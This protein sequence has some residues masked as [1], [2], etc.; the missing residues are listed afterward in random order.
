MRP[1]WINVLGKTFLIVSCFFVILLRLLLWNS[2]RSKTKINYNLPQS[3]GII[4]KEDQSSIN[5]AR[6]HLKGLIRERKIPGISIAVSKEGKIVWSEAFGY[7]DLNKKIKAQTTTLF[8]VASVSKSFTAAGMMNLVENKKLNLHASVQTYVPEF[9]DKEYPVTPHLLASHQAGIRN[10]WDDSETINTIH[11]NSVISSLEKFKNDSLLFIPGTNFEYSNYGYVLLSALIER[12]SGKDFI[13]YM[14]ENVFQPLGM[15]NTMPDQVKDSNIAKSTF[16]DH[17]TPYSSNG[18]IVVSPYN[19]LSCKWAS[20][21]FLSTAEDMV[22]FANGHISGNKNP[23][24]KKESIDSLFKPRVLKMGIF[25]Y[26]YGWMTARD[27]YLRKAYFHFG[28]SSGGTSFLVIYPKQKVAIAIVCNLG[29]AKFPYHS[30]INIVN[31]FVKRSLLPFYNFL[32]L[33]ALLYLLIK[34]IHLFKRK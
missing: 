21:G 23:Y 7:A 19:D 30:L 33:C 10:Y 18:E 14:H 12:A 6:N 27:P 15:M 11:Y 17:V 28:A 26:C 31:S 20:G 29:H 32:T 22:R 4:Y 9:P 8:R 13:S 2:E 25:G 34:F 16:Y 3:A 5:A 24:L 1:K